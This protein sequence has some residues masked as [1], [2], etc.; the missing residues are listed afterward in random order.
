MLTGASL[1]GAGGIGVFLHSAYLWTSTLWQAPGP[2]GTSAAGGSAC[3]C[4]VTCPTFPECP[5]CFCAE[6]PPAKVFEPCGPCPHCLTLGVWIVLALSLALSFFAGFW[7]NRCCRK[8]DTVQNE[9]HVA[10]TSG[11]PFRPAVHSPV[12]HCSSPCSH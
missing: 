12:L 6:C 11:D 7:C 2:A 9:V 8:G 10:I 5:P 4:E 3:I 1:F